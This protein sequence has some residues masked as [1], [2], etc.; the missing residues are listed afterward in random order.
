M[1]SKPLND[2]ARDT[3][4]R[5]LY[6]AQER[7]EN[8]NLTTSQVRDRLRELATQVRADENVV[9]PFGETNLISAGR[10]AVEVPALSRGPS[11]H[12]AL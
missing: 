6:W 4:A 8:S 5:E 7:A 9:I 1:A 2:K 12:V 3:L 10:G 11:R